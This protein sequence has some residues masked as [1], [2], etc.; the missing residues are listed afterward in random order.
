[1]KKLLHAFPYGNL[2]RWFLVRMPAVLAWPCIVCCWCFM[3]VTHA[4]VLFTWWLF[5][6]AFFYMLGVFAGC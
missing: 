3:A 5:V 6:A 2:K 4:F 1:M